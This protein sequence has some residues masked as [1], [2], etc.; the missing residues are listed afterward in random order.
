MRFISLSG[1]VT[2][3][4]QAKSF[5]R[6]Q[7][8]DYGNENIHNVKSINSDIYCDNFAVAVEKL[9]RSTLSL[10]KVNGF[11]TNPTDYSTLP[12]VFFLCD[13]SF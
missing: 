6:S 5:N 11:G 9:S 1:I 8:D 13:L 3:S 10:S 12:E 7:F 2:V 4:F